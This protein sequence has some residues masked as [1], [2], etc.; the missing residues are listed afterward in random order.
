MFKFFKYIFLLIF[1]AIFSN[2]YSNDGV[3]KRTNTSNKHLSELTKSNNYFAI[4]NENT[5]QF[6]V[7]NSSSSVVSQLKKPFLNFFK[8][9][10]VEQEFLK[11]SFLRIQ[12]TRCNN[13][14]LYFLGS[15]IIYP[16]H[17]FW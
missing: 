16:F 10:F 15:D 11:K 17:S 9:S 5:I 4:Q 1:V 12:E 3:L 13:V 2:G 14:F 7:A 6:S 8:F